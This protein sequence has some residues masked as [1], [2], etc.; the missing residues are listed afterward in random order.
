MQQVIPLDSS[1]NQTLATT[2]SVDGQP[3]PLQFTFQYNE[4]ARYWSMSVADRVGN[5][6]LVGIPLITGNDPAC[7][8][9]QQF[10]YLQ[11]GSCYVINASGTLAKPY[12]DNTDLGT[13]FILLWGDTA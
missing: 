4:I 2:L 13:D 3:L 10:A 5:L 6:L 11:I 8:L 9:L 1:P 7:N 12:P